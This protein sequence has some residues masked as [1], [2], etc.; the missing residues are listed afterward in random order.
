MIERILITGGAG[1][2]GSRLAA[3]LL[4]EGHEVRVLDSL[5]EQVHGARP[6][7]ASLPAP[8]EL[9][10]GNVLSWTALQAALRGTTVVVHLAAD[11]GTGQ[12]MYEIDRYVQTNAGGTGRLLDVLANTRHTVR[13]IVVASSRAVY[14]EGAY[15]TAD[16]R[17]VHPGPR[18]E[19]D[20]VRGDFDIHIS[21][22]DVLLPVP[23][24]ES[25]PPRPSSVYGI[26]K[27]VQE[28][29]VTTAAPAIGIEA[30]AL[31][32]Q[33]VYGPGQSLT[34]PYTGI[35]SIFSGI[36]RHGAEVN[37]FEDGRESRDFVFVDDVVEA[38]RLA[39]LHP[40][41]R[42]VYNVGSGTSTTVV[43]V[44]EAL[45]AAFDV[46]ARMR[47]S[48]TYRAGDIRHSIADSGRIHRA[49]GW[50]PTTTFAAG[51]RLF[52]EWVRDQP[53]DP[54]GYERSLVE[55]SARGLFK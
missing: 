38:T 46:E 17:I 31:R 5:S 52:A 29:L 22:E 8:V 12:S 13:R 47:I 32:Y 42:G 26:T 14:G 27:H 40:A 45:A 15:R 30:V 16:G 36:L 51:V 18:A 53:A 34:N 41:A 48:G 11:T 19:A 2:I 44:V 33:N 35:L 4:A 7:R 50:M 43:E 54:D 10:Q 23:T 49:L 24:T 25:A 6:G 3:R 37:V 1:F 55:M 20:L 39:A 28:A 21:G 9:I